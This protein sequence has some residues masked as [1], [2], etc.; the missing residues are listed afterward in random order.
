[1]DAPLDWV[2]VLA[3]A[4][5]PVVVADDPYEYTM[6]ELVGTAVLLAAGIEAEPEVDAA[7]EFPVAL[8]RKASNVLGLDA[9]TFKAN[10]MPDSQWPV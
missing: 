5:V 3:E 4:L 8:A 1:M 2:V 10:T 6:P 9:F 7:V